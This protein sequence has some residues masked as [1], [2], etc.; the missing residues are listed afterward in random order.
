[1][2]D[3]ELVCGD[4]HQTTWPVK[5]SAPEAAACRAGLEVVEQLLTSTLLSYWGWPGSLRS[6]CSA[7][8][9]MGGEGEVPGE[10]VALAL[11]WSMQRQDIGAEQDPDPRRRSRSMLSPSAG[12]SPWAAFR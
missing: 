9:M 2:A 10:L 1:M 4:D 11:A 6:W 12:C 5:G 3:V 7:A 8:S